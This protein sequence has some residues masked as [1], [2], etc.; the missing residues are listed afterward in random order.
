MTTPTVSI[1]IP[2]HNAL[3]ALQQCLDSLKASGVVEKS[4]VIIVDDGS[5]NATRVFLEQ[6]VAGLEGVTLF[7][8]P[9][10]RGFSTAVNVGL[11]MA[12]GDVVV[13]LNSDT[14]V[15]RNWVEPLVSTLFSTPGAGIV[16]PLSNGARYQSVPRFRPSIRETWANQSV[17]NKVNNPVEFANQISTQLR[18]ANIEGPIRVPLLHGFCLGI[19][20]EVLEHIGH[21]DEL[22]FP[23]GYGSEEDFCYRA[24]DSGWSA[25]VCPTLYVW[26]QKSASYLPSERSRMVATAKTRMDQMYSQN[27]RIETRNSLERTAAYLASALEGFL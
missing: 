11:G 4:Q 3:G 7:R 8:S 10:N 13:V 9:E 5:G 15:P 16:G 23:D 1:I 24:I 14:V 26:H 19:K 27:R 25:V 20:R 21:F 17:T 12:L 2:V 18:S 6:S 22:N